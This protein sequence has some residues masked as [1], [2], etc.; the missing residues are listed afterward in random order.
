MEGTT[1]KTVAFVTLGCKLN[2]S[3][4]S[5]IAQQFLD[6][7]YER[8]AQSKPADIYVINT[9][10]VTEH[11]D[12]KCRQAIRKLHKQNPDAIIAV[13]GCYAQLKP[14]EIMAI[15]GVDLV[16]GADRKGDVFQLVSEIP[17]K[18][19]TARSYSCAINE[20]ETIF[21]AFSHGERTRSFLK[22]QDGCNY[23][24]S[25]CTIPLARGKS[26]NLPIATLVKE[27]EA[28][29]AKGIKEVVLTGVN[30]GDYGRTTGEDFLDLL[31]ALNEVEGIERY[32]I[33]SIEP[34][35]LRED[36][37]EWIASGTKFQN[38]FHI[39]L[40]CGSDAVLKVMRRRY[41]TAM[42]A[43]KIEM[44]RRI[45][46][47]VFFGI[48]VIVGFPG[49]TDEEFQNCY[50]FLKDTIKPAF[51][52]VFPYSRR[53]NTPAAE[54]PNQVHEATKTARVEALTSLSEELH[55]A[56]IERHK[57]TVQEVLFESTQKG[58]MMYGYTGNYIRVERPYDKNKIGQICT[59]TI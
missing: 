18:L 31:K 46:G 28:I 25:Y 4:T 6:N 56:Y 35:L 40:Q 53:A 1:N 42:F 38:H 9:C 5:T 21:P 27:A 45:M 49:E 33:S 34:N 52:H 50:N 51:I 37:I 43:E 2:F 13:T 19:G 23:H 59:E 17:S 14:A 54:M 22:V 26:R 48:D 12:K 30:T 29:A 32:R 10:S 55:N 57:G 47:D 16:V 39:P 24:C 58:G 11:A 44:V 8:V 3:E 36:I 20:V 41:T 15:E 7:G